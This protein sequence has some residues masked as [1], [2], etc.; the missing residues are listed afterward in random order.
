MREPPLDWKE[1]SSS[2][3]PPAGQVA[4]LHLLAET[5]AQKLHICVVFYFDIL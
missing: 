4:D 3:V 5:N 2:L 1:Q